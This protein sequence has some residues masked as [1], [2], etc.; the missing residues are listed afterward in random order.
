MIMAMIRITTNS[1]DKLNAPLLCI[2]NL[3]IN[4]YLKVLKK[5]KNYLMISYSLE[6]MIMNITYTI[7]PAIKYKMPSCTAWLMTLQNPN[8][9]IN[10]PNH[11]ILS[12]TNF[13]ISNSSD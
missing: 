9:M 10:K 11:N 13:K 2:F 7:A 8:S 4:T 1:I 12:N 6:I 5:R 3:R